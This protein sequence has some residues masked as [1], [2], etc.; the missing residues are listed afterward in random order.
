[1]ETAISYRGSHSTMPLSLSVSGKAANG[2]RDAEGQELEVSARELADLKA[3]PM[4]MVTEIEAPEGDTP[5]AENA[6]R[7][8][9][10]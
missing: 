2:Y 3:D 4:L 6:D 9:N 1:M 5:E 7:D 10:V 8:T